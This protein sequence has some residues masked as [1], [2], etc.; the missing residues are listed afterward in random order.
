VKDKQ[1]RRVEI[2]GGDML[3]GDMQEVISGIS[4]GQQVIGNALELQNTV[5]Q[6]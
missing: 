5:Q 3:P 2:V 1:F 6:Q 4:A